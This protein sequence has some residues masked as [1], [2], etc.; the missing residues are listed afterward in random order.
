MVCLGFFFAN[1]ITKKDNLVSP[2]NKIAPVFLLLLGRLSV[3]YFYP[4][5]LGNVFI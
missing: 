1:D 4:P 5:L 2:V 3:R